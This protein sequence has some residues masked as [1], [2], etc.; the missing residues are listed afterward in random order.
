MAQSTTL[1]IGM[2]VHKE[3][4]TGAYVAKDHAA[5][6]VPLGTFGTRP[7]DIDKRMRKLQAQATH[8]V[9]VYEAGPGGSW[10]YRSLMQRGSVCWGVAPS[11]MPP[12]AGDRVNPDRRDAMPLARRMRSGDLPPVD[13]PAVDA[14]ARRALRRAREE[15][16]RELQAAKGRRKAFWL[17]PDI[18]STGRA[19]W[20]PAHLRWRSEVGWPTPAHQMV[21]Q[22]YGQTGTAQTERLGRLALARHEQGHPWRFSPV[23]EALQA[24][25]GGQ[26]TVAV[27]MVAALG[28]LT[29]CE[30][31]RQRMHD[32]GLTPAASA[33]GGRRPHGRMTQTGPTQARRALVEGAWAYRYPATGSRPRPRRLAKLPAALQASSGQAQVRRCTRD[34]H[35][36]AKGQNAPQVVVAMAREWRAFLWAL[37]KHLAVTPQAERRLRVCR[38][39]APRFSRLSAEAPP[40]CGATLGSVT[41]PHG[42]RGPRMRQAPDG[43]Q[44]GGTQPTAISVIHRRVFLAPPPPIDNKEK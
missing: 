43:G 31:P 27:A 8:L 6:V 34:R 25:R 30:N 16:L 1:Y 10:R 22:D 38:Q 24:W 35:L 21:V 39:S 12:R 11:W 20:R 28:D 17:R 40:R 37:A 19:H 33:R 41:R 15:T 2:E 3:S 7:C 29:R 9:F 36:R 26:G 4:I 44:E 14:A 5:A 42:T 23:V 18:R 13:V 32:L